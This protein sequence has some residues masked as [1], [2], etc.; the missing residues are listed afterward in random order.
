MKCTDHTKTPGNTHLCFRV[1]SY[2]TQVCKNYICHV[3][4][5][6]IYEDVT[7]AGVPSTEVKYYADLA[8]SE[9]KKITQRVCCGKRSEELE[10]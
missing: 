1:N 3:C 2:V 8:Y 10:K 7:W 5:M 6:Y 4:V 9:A